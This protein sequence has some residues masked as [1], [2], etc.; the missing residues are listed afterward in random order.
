[1]PNVEG[2]VLGCIEADFCNEYIRFAAFLK[3][4]KACSLLVLTDAPPSLGVAAVHDL[5]NVALRRFG[6]GRKRRITVFD[7]MKTTVTE[8]RVACSSFFRGLFV[9][10]L[11][12]SLK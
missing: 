8:V 12:L 2:L 10:R 11:A 4:Y 1:M 3:I 6:V 9:V 7:A 5:P